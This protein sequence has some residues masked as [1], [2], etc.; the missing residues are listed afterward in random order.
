[1]HHQRRPKRDRAAQIGRG[2][3]VVDDQR[4]PGLVGHIGQ[5]PDIGDITARVG[6][7]FAKDRAG[8]GVT[9]GSH[10]HQIVGIDEFGRPAELADRVGKLLHRAAVKPGRC[11][12]I[13]ARLHQREQRHDL[14]GVTRRA[15][16]RPDAAFQRRHPF[17]QRRHRGVGQAGIDIADL[18]QIEQFRGMFAV[19]EHIGRG[20][21]DRHLPRPGCRVRLG[22]GVNLQRVKAIGWRVSHHSLPEWLRGQVRRNR[23]LRQSRHC[24]GRAIA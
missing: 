19:A 12:H 4:H 8:V 21:I 23:S 15:A 22:P 1:M 11:H 7:A 5:R 6:D 13:A 14:R 20:L 16:H 9:G 17:G 2:G 10:R 18:L 24:A 3:G